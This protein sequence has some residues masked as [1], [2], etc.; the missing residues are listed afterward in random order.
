MAITLAFQA[1]DAGSIPAA[2]SKHNREIKKLGIFGLPPFQRQTLLSVIPYNQ[3]KSLSFKQVNSHDII[4]QRHFILPYHPIYLSFIFT[5]PLFSILSMYAIQYVYNWLQQYIASQIINNNINPNFYK[6]Y[7]LFFQYLNTLQ[8]KKI[9][10]YNPFTQ[11]KITRFIFN[12]NTMQKKLA[13]LD[14]DNTF[15]Q[16]LT[17]FKKK[18]YTLCKVNHPDKHPNQS[19]YHIKMRDINHSYQEITTIIT[20]IQVLFNIDK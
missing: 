8:E 5:F 14:V 15:Y 13:I 7:Q 3:K 9:I 1:R 2:R 19:E 17:E 10:N 18:Y 4:Y 20:N 12:Q 16:N 11:E 6:Y